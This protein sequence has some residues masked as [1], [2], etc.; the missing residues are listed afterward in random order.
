MDVD[1]P[2]LLDYYASGVLELDEL[3][4]QRL[5]LEELA[6]GFDRLRAGEGDVH[7]QLVVFNQ[8]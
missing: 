5:T 2:R 1:I 6:D 4:S 7:R 8:T 3:V